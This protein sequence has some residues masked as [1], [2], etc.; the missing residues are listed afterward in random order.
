MTLH[1]TNGLFTEFAVTRNDSRYVG[2]KIHFT[3][4]TSRQKIACLVVILCDN[5]N[6]NTPPSVHLYLHGVQ[7]FE[8][9]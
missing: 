6:C 7:D 1:T 9:S 4:S 8:C 2:F 3:G 5:I